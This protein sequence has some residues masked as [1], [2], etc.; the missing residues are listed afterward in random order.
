MFDVRGRVVELGHLVLFLMTFTLTKVTL[1]LLECLHY[2][3]QQINR[4]CYTYMY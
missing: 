4:E 2:N 3:L 1:K